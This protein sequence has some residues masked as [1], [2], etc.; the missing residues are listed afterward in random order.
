MANI[1]EDFKEKNKFC[2]FTSGGKWEKGRLLHCREQRES[3]VR[4]EFK[5]KALNRFEAAGEL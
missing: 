2:M 3:E 1:I 5:C 4:G